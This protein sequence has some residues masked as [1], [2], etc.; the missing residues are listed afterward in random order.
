MPVSTE[1]IED[2]HGNCCVV[3]SNGSPKHF[4]CFPCREML[5]YIE[6]VNTYENI[7]EI[8]L[9]AIAVHILR[10]GNDAGEIE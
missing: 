3:L 7:S 4:E 1:A 5:D 9:C 8:P 2:A 10:Y 6:M